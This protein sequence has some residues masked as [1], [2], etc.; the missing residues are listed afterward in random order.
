LFIHTI[1]KKRSMKKTLILSL[2]A[3]LIFATPAAIK[4]RLY[5]VGDSTSCIY[6]S[7]QYPRTGWAQILQNY[8][9]ID[10][11]IVADNAQSGRSSK[12]FY[13]E[14]HWAPIKN[15][16]RKGDYVIIQFGHNDEKIGKDSTTKLFLNLAAGESPNYPGGNS[17]NTHLQERGAKA[18][19]QLMVN[20]ISRQKIAPLHT[21]IKGGMTSVRSL[22]ASVKTERSFLP[23]ALGTT[24]PA[25]PGALG[26]GA[27]ATGGRC[28]T[29][30]HVTN[31]NDAGAGSFRDAVSAPNRIVVF[32]VG[33]Y[34]TLKSAVLVKSNTT[35]AG[36]TAPGEGIGFRGGELS[37]ANQFNAICRYIRI[38]PGSETES[39]NDDALSLYR[40]KNVILDHCSF[41]FAPWNNIDGVGD[42]SSGNLVTDISFQHCLIA[43]PTGQ[44]FGAHCESVNSSWSW[45]YC[46]FANSHN[47][48]PLAKVNDIFVNNVLY[49][50]SAGYTT[51]T[52]TLFKHDI[53]NNYFI[54][55][56]A[57][58]GTDNTWFQI[59]KNQSIYSSGNIKD[60]NQD[61]ILNGDTTVPSWYQ[62]EGTI[63]PAPWAPLPS[64]V[65]VYSAKTA[66]RFAASLAGTLPR[67]RLD[68]LIINQVKTLGK[69]TAGLTAGTAGP[70]SGL[71]TS[72][73]QTGLDNNGYGTIRGG[74]KET[75]SDNDGMPDFWEKA[76]GAKV[77]GDDAMTAGSDGY[78]NI[79][80]YINWLADPHARSTIN[81]PVD[82]N[83]SAYADGFLGVSPVFTVK[84]TRN[85]ASELLPDG[86][87]AR[88]TPT[89]DFFGIGSFDVNV[90][91]ADVTGYALTVSVII[92]PD[93][94]G[95]TGG[96]S[97]ISQKTEAAGMKIDRTGE[98][99]ILTAASGGFYE[100]VN[101]S[102]RRIRRGSLHNGRTLEIDI[103]KLEYGLYIL[104]INA[105]GPY[106]SFRFFKG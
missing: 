50:C 80:R 4:P 100:I 85:G 41:E 87:T 105:G 19:A 5:V 54:F 26:F 14:G 1:E 70:T 39:D 17:D 77:N 10:S 92:V 58:T 49:N 16:L 66:Y 88:F 36:Q 18:I 30:Y 99:L 60:K 24:L 2:S 59:D 33:G 8:F 63:L 69:A 22:P 46:I 81:T 38:R 43:D 47:R 56:P 32:D 79:E 52:S 76:V 86:F 84:N 15:E 3:F 13:D 51:H 6:S 103:S 9:V 62:G 42:N 68:S 20:D 29:V 102:G 34:I 65:T 67:D 64:S 78:A 48:N 35:I 23:P 97:R 98:K 28:G 74:A 89:K 71:Y 90:I 12:S 101:I 82:I 11:V 96:N 53:I 37:Y 40:A 75:D 21:W 7:S 106:S 57:S 104:N 73:T 95:K 55:G 27:K 83:L 94:T 44:Q 31:L 91:G 45:F 93:L 25:F 61:G 72:Q